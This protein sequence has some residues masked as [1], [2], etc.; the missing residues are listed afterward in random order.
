[1]KKAIIL[2]CSAV[3]MF[4]FTG[5]AS[6]YGIANG[7]PTVLPGVMISSNTHGGYIAP[8]MQSMK[9]V[10]VLGPAS[11]EVSSTNTLL[12]ISAGDTSIAKAKGIAMRQY[13][14][15]DDI[16]NVEIDVKHTGVL[17]LFNTVTMYYKGIAV[18]YVK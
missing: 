16:V 9:D 4:I 14:T 8:K 10:V 7:F 15:A 12:L 18:R 11:A 1:M 6:Q 5:C 17:G 3:T 13:P 2:A